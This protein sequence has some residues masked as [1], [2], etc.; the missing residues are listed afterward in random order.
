MSRIASNLKAIRRAAGLTQ[1]SLAEKLGVNR[2]AIGAY[3]E[4]R[5]EPRLGTLVELARIFDVTMDDLVLKDL[6][7]GATPLP[8]VSDAAPRILSIAVDSDRNEE[9]ISVVPVKAAAGYLHGY[10]DLDFIASLP[11]FRMPVKELP[12]DQTLRMFQVE[13]DSMLPLPGGSYVVCTYV[14]DLATAGGAQPY[15]VVTRDEGIVF[16][17]VENLLASR[18]GYRLISDNADYP[19]YEVEARDVIEMWKARAFLQFELPGELNRAVSNDK[20]EDIR[21]SLRRIEDYVKR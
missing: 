5:A 9:L 6:A 13:G 17:R 10:G 4:G 8:F 19:P 2:S 12:Q 20:I 3:E 15:I 11:T 16:K 21:S 14:E 7:G 1:A 18:G